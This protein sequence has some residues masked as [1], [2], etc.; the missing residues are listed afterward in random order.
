[1]N[2]RLP[3]SRLPISS[4]GF[5]ITASCPAESDTA[6]ADPNRLLLDGRCWRA[7]HRRLGESARHASPIPEASADACASSPRRTT[8]AKGFGHA[9]AWSSSGARGRTRTRHVFAPPWRGEPPTIPLIDALRTFSNE[10]WWISATG[11]VERQRAT[12]YEERVPDSPPREGWALVTSEAVARMIGGAKASG[13]FI[14]TGDTEQEMERV[15]QLRYR[16]RAL[17]R[18]KRTLERHELDLARKVKVVAKWRAK[19][20][21]LSTTRNVVRVSTTSSVDKRVPRSRAI[22]GII[23]YAPRQSLRREPLRPP[24]AYSTE[25]S[26]SRTQRP[27]TQNN[28]LLW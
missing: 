20:E 15:A 16:A 23:P 24:K 14:P 12:L 2:G 7:S 8:H 18:A 11:A 3:N 9:R 26:P 19:V 25:A 4:M 28:Y 10:H 6:T 27:H 17:E 5:A 1:M 22:R 21:Q 13:R